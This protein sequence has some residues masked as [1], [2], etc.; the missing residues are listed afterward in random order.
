MRVTGSSTEGACLV[1]D[2]RL[3]DPIGLQRALQKGKDAEAS[4]NLYGV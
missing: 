2:L 3:G 4:E 1:K